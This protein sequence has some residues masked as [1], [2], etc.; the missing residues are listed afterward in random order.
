M[1][2]TKSVADYKS[3]REDYLTL[4]DDYM[5]LKSILSALVKELKTVH[6]V[7]KNKKMIALFEEISEV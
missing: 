4:L 7:V 5:R 6:S 3:L 1:T 2:E